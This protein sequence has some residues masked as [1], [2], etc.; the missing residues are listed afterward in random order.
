[1]I[2][3][4]FAGGL[5]NNLFQFANIYNL[6]KKYSLPYIINKEH[7]RL[8]FDG[9][10]LYKDGRFDQ[11][12]NL[13]IPALFD[14]YFNY[15]NSAKYDIGRLS[16]YV[17]RDMAHDDHRFI[18]ME[19][20]D[21]LVYKGYFQSYKYHDSF[22][23]KEEFVLNKDRGLQ[24]KEKNALCFTKPTIALHYRLSGDRVLQRIQKYHKNVDV[25]FYKKS[26]NTIAKIENKKLEDYNTLLFTDD[27]E[28][29]ERL[30]RKI[31]IIPI[32]VSSKD[33]IRDFIFMSL[34]THNIIGNST[35]S[36]WAAYLN[37]NDNK[38]VIAPKTEFLGPALK[39]VDLTDM[40]PSTWI[41]I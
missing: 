34:C 30:L 8:T 1:M 40:F 23:P 18:E 24:I 19:K 21:N 5:G 16:T 28:L 33:N 27:Q 20:R 12:S 32:N 17:H 2:T 14:N 37:K 36:W 15:C 9:K 26:I 41:T 25:E 29:A 38:I 3:C 7:V 11:E 39:H 10:Q 22:D 35:Y 31:N 4:D 13:E 6:H